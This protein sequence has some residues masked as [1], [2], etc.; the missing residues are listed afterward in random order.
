M[1]MAQGARDQVATIARATFSGFLRER[2]D[3]VGHAGAGDDL[4]GG[5]PRGAVALPARHRA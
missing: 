5:V 1:T 2:P 3:A 4:G